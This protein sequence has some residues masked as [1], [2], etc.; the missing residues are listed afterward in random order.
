VVSEAEK[1]AWLEERLRELEW[2]TTEGFGRHDE[3]LDQI[4]ETLRQLISPP[5]RP[6]HPVGFRLPEDDASAWEETAGSAGE[7]RPGELDEVLAGGWLE[8]APP[9]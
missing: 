6:K 5:A 3:Q 8:R 4:F 2:E 9:R 7:A 1:K